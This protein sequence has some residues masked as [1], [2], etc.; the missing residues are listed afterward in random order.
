MGCDPGNWN[1]SRWD[2]YGYLDPAGTSVQNMNH[3][4]QGVRKDNF[5]MYDYLTDHENKQHYGS[6]NPPCYNLANFAAPVA[7]FSG[8]NDDLADPTD[9][10][11][12]ISELNPSLIKYQT[13]IS[14]YEHMDFVWGMDAHTVLY[15]QIISLFEE[16]A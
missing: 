14:Y 10:Q 12:L 1:Q 11:R 6:R 2:V 7:L 9:V 16:F 13:E 8:G 15:P 4:G 3:W 5:C